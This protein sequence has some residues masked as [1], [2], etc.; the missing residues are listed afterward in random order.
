MT[1][2]TARPR[3]LPQDVLDHCRER[4]P[5]YDAAN[6]FF[7]EDLEDLR[8]AGYLLASVPEELGGWGL[9]LDE[10]AL[11]QRRLARHAPATA[12]ALTMHLYWTG[13][14]ANLHRLGVTTTDFVLREAAAGEV[15]ASGHAEAGNDVPIQLS[16][17]T[18][19]RVDGGWR[20]T[21]RKMFGS[22]GPVWTRMGLHAMDASNP[23]GPVVVHLFADR[24]APGVEVVEK[25]D[26]LSMRATQSYDT[27]FDGVFVPDDR[28]G[29]VVPAGV[30]HPFVGTMATWALV[31]IQNVY[32]GIA[33]RAFELAV[34]SA[35]R[36][37]S[38]GIP[39][40]TYAHNPHVQHQIAEM[41]LD[42]ETA[43]AVVDRLAAD[44]VTGAV[45]LDTW[46]ARLFGGKVIVTQAA[47]RVVD[48]ALDVTGGAGISRGNEIERLY[49]DV[50]AGGFHPPNDAFAHE[51]VGKTVLGIAPGPARW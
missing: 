23:D 25:W 12:L 29:A 31:L 35:Q 18:A 4:A 20:I 24:D 33:E 40:G 9:D 1:T 22:L 47:R 15:F 26:T 7:H 8:A 28:V 17:T 51:V 2:T 50:R 39:A 14:A 44:W 21:G 3:T 41:F 37:T 48:L 42:L 6:R 5:G 36:R 32:V 27:K 49:R 11:E 19:E 38:I 10:L 30:P 43:R 16:T 45:E 46:P 34:E 13:T